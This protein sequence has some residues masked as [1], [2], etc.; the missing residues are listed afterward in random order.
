MSTTIECRKPNG[1]LTDFICD[2]PEFAVRRYLKEAKEEGYTEFCLVYVPPH[3]GEDFAEFVK[4][5]NN[6]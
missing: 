4:G 5:L 2:E 6:E 1:K 3:W